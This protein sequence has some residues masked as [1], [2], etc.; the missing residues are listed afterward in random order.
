MPCNCSKGTT[1]KATTYVVKNSSGTK[2]FSTESAAA[3]E[4]ALNGGSYTKQ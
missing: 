3:R 2:T 4:V 1:Q